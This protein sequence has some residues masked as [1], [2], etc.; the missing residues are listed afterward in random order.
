MCATLG[1]YGV[2]AGIEGASLCVLER[3][4]HV[5]GLQKGGLEPPY[6]RTLNWVPTRTY[7]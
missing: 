4:M 2:L 1:P 5:G 3:L 7:K 6:I